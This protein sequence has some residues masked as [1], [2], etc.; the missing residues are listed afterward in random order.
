MFNHVSAQQ[1]TGTP[2][3]QWHQN[4]GRWSLHSRHESLVQLRQPLHEVVQVKLLK[5]IPILPCCLH[6]CTVAVASKT[7]TMVGSCTYDANYECNLKLVGGEETL[8]WVNLASCAAF[9]TTTTSAS[10]WFVMYWHACN[11]P[12]AN[13]VT[14]NQ[15]PQTSSTASQQTRANTNTNIDP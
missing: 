11:T 5:L 14:D 9:S 8:T 3:K 13:S 4:G 7:G 2:S 12:S 6:S 1:C 15:D 10:E